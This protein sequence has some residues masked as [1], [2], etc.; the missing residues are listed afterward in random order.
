MKKWPGREEKDQEG[1]QTWKP[2][3]KE[4][5]RKEWM[6]VLNAAEKTTKVQISSH[7]I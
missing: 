3:E 5:S 1:Q 7:Q 4:D 6:G 2:T